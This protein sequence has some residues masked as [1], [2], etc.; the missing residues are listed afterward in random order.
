LLFSIEKNVS[1]NDI[2][3]VIINKYIF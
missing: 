2:R 1:L 3:F